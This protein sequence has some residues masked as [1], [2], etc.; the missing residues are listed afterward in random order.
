MGRDWIDGQQ[1]TSDWDSDQIPDELLGAYWF[2]NVS[3]C[4]TE[5]NQ[6]HCL[7][8]SDWMSVIRPYVFLQSED[9]T[10]LLERFDQMRGFFTWSS[11]QKGGMV[12]IC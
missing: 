9:K 12:K 4:T 1:M 10:Y 3:D 8:I 11:T 5:W 2:T 7:E 6:A